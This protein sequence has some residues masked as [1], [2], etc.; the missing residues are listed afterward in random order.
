MASP[1]IRDVA[2]NAAPITTLA[3]LPGLDVV[4]VFGAGTT[5]TIT[6]VGPASVRHASVDNADAHSAWADVPAGDTVTI[7]A[8][9]VRDLQLSGTGQAVL[10][11]VYG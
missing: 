11:L 7:A 1:T 3:L 10:D 8:D 9:E 4:R 2:G 6:N 5:I